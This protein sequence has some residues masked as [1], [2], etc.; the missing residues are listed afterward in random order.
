MVKGLTEGGKKKLRRALRMIIIARRL[1]KI[2]MKMRLKKKIRKAV[3]KRR[4][5]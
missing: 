2:A 5:K 3:R 1:K 4:R